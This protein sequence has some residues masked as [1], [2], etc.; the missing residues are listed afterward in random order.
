MWSLPLL[1]N[2]KWK[3]DI[4]QWKKIKELKSVQKWHKVFQK[5]RTDSEVTHL[6]TLRPYW[7]IL[8]QVVCIIQGEKGLILYL[9]TRLILETIGCTGNGDLTG[10]PASK[11]PALSS[12]SPSW[13][14]KYPSWSY[15]QA[16]LH[17]QPFHGHKPTQLRG[18]MAPG[19]SEFWANGSASLDLICGSIATSQI[20]PGPP[21]WPEMF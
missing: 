19:S 20:C 8:N 5:L 17:A 16:P 9:S 14:S 6:S 18:H 13:C 7:N 15:L 3:D 1:G 10:R 12:S 21:C 4:S 11:K 2:G